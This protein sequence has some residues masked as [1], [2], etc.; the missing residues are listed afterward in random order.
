MGT[1]IIVIQ[2][3][4]SLS[5]LVIIHEF[6]HFIFARLFGM[7]VDKFYIFFNPWFSLFKWKPKNSE[8]EYGIGWLPLGG[9]TKIAGMIDE[10]M[11]TEQMA[12]PAQPWEFRSHPAWQRLLV[13]L[14]GVLFNLLLAFVIF[15]GI[16]YVYGEKYLPMQEVT[17]GMQFSDAAKQAGFKDG[18]ILLKADTTALTALDDENMRLVLNAEKVTVKRDGQT[19]TV[20]LP[21]DFVNS[22]M[23][24]GKGFCNYRMPFVVDSVMKGAPAE[25]VLRAG[26]EVISVSNRRLYL[27]DIAITLNNNPNHALVIGIIRKGDTLNTRIT[28][29]SD[30]KIGVYMKGPNELYNIAEKRYSLLESIPAGV[31]KSLKKL[32]GY[33]SDFKY[34]FSKEGASSVGGFGTLATLFPDTFNWYAFWNLTAFISIILAFANILPIPG[35]DGGHIV[36]LLYEMVTR[37]KPSQAF[38]IR[39]Q[40]LG[41]A[42]LL[43][44]F[45]YANINDLFR[46]LN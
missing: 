36:F 35:L 40:M 32:T 38:L 8:T 14:G 16:Y 24:E 21:S 39:A 41:M 18:D 45:L 46:F 26:D 6:G 19:Q 29:N 1:L 43:F 27:E 33:V 25:G 9:Y 31:G 7:R 5:L 17:T 2:L 42:L 44:I 28:P 22:L 4:A 20:T 37:R 13:M 23:A 34:V 30:G 10:S 11:D 12:K 3:L 15:S